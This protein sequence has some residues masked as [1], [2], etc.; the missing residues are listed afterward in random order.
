MFVALLFCC[1]PSMVLGQD[2]ASEIERLQKQ[3]SI[4]QRQ[5][6]EMKSLLEQQQKELDTL[7]A[8]VG[9]KAAQPPVPEPIKAPPAT[10]SSGRVEKEA[11]TFNSLSFRIGGAEFAPGGFL[12][13]STVRRSTNGGSGVATSFGTIPANDSPAGKL[14]EWRF[15]TFNSRLTLKVTEQ[16]IEGRTIS[17]AAYFEVDFAGAAPST[18]YITGNSNAFRMRQAWGSVQM[19]KLEILGGQA[20]TLMTPN[21]TGTSPVPSDVFIGLG[22]DSSYLAGLVFVRQSQVRATYRM[23]PHW[24]A[25]FSVENP[26]QYVTGATM[27]PSGFSSQFDNSSGNPTVPNA[28]PDFVAKIA[29]DAKLANRAVHFDVAGLSR[30]FRTLTADNTKISSPG[31][32]GSVNL[33][34]EPVKNLRWILTAFFSSGGGRYIMGMGPDAI[35]GPDGS[36]SPVHSI[37]GIAGLEYQFSR[38][39]QVY[40]YYSGAYFARNYVTVSPGNYLGFGYPGSSNLANRQVQEATIGYARTFWKTPNYGAFQALGQYAYVT[41]APWYVAPASDSSMHTHMIF[42]GLR[43]TLP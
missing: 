40:A 26:Q 5:L 10:A 9:H 7:S 16:P 39:S 43:F 1:G 41:R 22:Q 42:S 8:A 20:W 23:T 21:R 24:T 6:D 36:I 30:Q 35:V 3:V 14:S 2:N 38:A 17:A 32:G 25:A 27:L 13:L 37:S 18:A 28:R 15:S 29:L 12:D 31:V 34:V 11:T 19:G 33:V 4:Q